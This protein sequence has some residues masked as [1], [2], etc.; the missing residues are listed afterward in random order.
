[1]AGLLFA[2]F[3]VLTA[4]AMIV[5]YRRRLLSSARDFVILG[6]LPLGATAFLVWMFIRS[7][8]AAPAAQVWSLIGVVAAGLLLMIAA[9]FG[10]RSVFFAVQRESDPGD[11]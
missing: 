1:V 11:R 6:L 9:R 8:Q 4:L 7:V 3:Y 10:L 5:Y 2:I